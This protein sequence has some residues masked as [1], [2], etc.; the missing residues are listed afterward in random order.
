LLVSIASTNFSIRT[1]VIEGVALGFGDDAGVLGL[2]VFG[3]VDLPDDS[4]HGFDAG[5]GVAG[6]GGSADRKDA[7]A[8][9]GWVVQTVI[10]WSNKGIL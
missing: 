8:R 9:T 10:T 1:R 5:I 6:A 3:G 4:D 7:N 2:G